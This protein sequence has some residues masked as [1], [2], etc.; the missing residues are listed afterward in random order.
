MKKKKPLFFIIVLV[1]LIVLLHATPGLALRTHVFML[2][3]PKAA[4]ASGIVDDDYHNRVD[5]DFFFVD[6]C[7]SLY[8]N[9]AAS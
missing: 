4:L 5:H 6:Q 1:A 8:I 2:G 3:Y 9:G 7:Q